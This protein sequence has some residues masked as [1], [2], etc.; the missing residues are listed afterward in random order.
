MGLPG[1]RVVLPVQ[2][3]RDGS[4]LRPILSHPLPS[5]FLQPFAEEVAL[6]SFNNYP[7][8]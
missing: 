1:G 2:V 8:C 7:F 3:G 6:C 4:R 5:F